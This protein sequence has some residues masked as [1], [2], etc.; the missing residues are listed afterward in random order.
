MPNAVPP[1]VPPDDETFS[2]WP[3]VISIGL[4]KLAT[5]IT[6]LYLSWG[7]ES[8]KMIASTLAPWIAVVTALL[9]APVGWHL[10]MRRMR[11]RREALMAAEFMEENGYPD[12]P[13]PAPESA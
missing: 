9:I 7:Q 2:A 8:G 11:R 3:L 10:R 4:A 13:I 12:V 1:P 6:I 5:L